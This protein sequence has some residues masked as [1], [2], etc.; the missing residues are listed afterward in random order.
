MQETQEIFASAEKLDIIR[1]PASVNLSDKIQN[2]VTVSGTAKNKEMG[3]EFVRLILSEEG[4]NILRQTGQPLII[5]PIRR[6]I[7]PKEVQ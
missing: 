4:Q 3:I 7:V 2:A 1:F 5:L 6:G